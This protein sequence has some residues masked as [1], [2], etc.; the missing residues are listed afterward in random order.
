MAG[1]DKKK[2]GK[3]IQK[4]KEYGFFLYMLPL[5]VTAKELSE[6]LDIVKK[7]AVEVWIEANLL[8]ITLEGGALIIE[9]MMPDLEG[10]E[11]REQLAGLKVKQVYACEYEMSDRVRVQK[12]M[13]HLIQNFGGFLASDTEDFAPFIKVEEL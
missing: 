3:V 11:D 8:E 10:A 13:A 2:T 5:A 6:K 7:E 1:K 4:P 12:I 9:D